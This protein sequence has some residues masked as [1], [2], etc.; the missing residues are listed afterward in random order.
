[1]TCQNLEDPPYYRCGPCPAGTTGNGTF[2]SDIDEVNLAETA[3]RRL[4]GSTDFGKYTL[5][6]SR[7]KVRFSQSL[8]PAIALSQF[9]YGF[10]LRFLP[11]RLHRTGRPGRWSGLRPPQ[12]AALRRHQRVRRREEW[13]MRP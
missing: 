3:V 5:G 10:P 12:P 1:V 7:C 11:S 2:C 6:F 4:F 9:D 8:R 13:R